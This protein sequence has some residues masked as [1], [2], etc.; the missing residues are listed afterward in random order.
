MSRGARMVVIMDDM[1]SQVL[2]AYRTMLKPDGSYSP[3]IF[4]APEVA[5][6]FKL[7]G[8]VWLPVG[9]GLWCWDSDHIEQH[10]LDSE[11]FDLDDDQY[12]PEM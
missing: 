2:Y 7:R 9:G 10:H 3:Y 11:D 8:G 1:P 12:D 5:K 6:D 4:M